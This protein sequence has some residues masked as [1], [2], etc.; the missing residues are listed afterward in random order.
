MVN[1][2]CGDLAEY[3]TSTIHH[4]TNLVTGYDN[5]Y[6]F[7]P[8]QSIL[9]W[10]SCNAPVYRLLVTLWANKPHTN[11]SCLV[12]LSRS[13]KWLWRHLIGRVLLNVYILLLLACSTCAITKV[14]LPFTI[15]DDYCY[16]LVDGYKTINSLNLASYAS[17]A[18]TIKELSKFFVIPL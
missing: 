16:S 3:H 7:Q 2:F 18:L 6:P 9:R 4:Y 11:Q 15:I 17:R 12:G 14:R 5:L 13:D 8:Y 10:T 1:K